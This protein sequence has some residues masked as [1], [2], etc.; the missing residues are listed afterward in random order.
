MAVPT[1]LAIMAVSLT[2]VVGYFSVIGIG[3]FTASVAVPAM[4]LAALIEVIKIALA[5][6]LHHNWRM[7]PFGIKMGGLAFIAV[8]MIIT[9][10]GVHNYLMTA[11]NTDGIK[12][13]QTK[14]EIAV[15]AAGLDADTKQRDFIQGQLAQLSKEYERYAD[16]G[17]VS[18]SRA[19]RQADK[20]ARA[21]LTE[22]LREVQAR[23]AAANAETAR[24]SVAVSRMEAS[25][26]PSM[27]LH[28][29]L[30]I[31][32]D[33]AVNLYT[34]LFL[35]VG[36]PLAVFLSVAAVWQMGQGRA[37]EAGAGAAKGSTLPTVPRLRAMFDRF[38]GTPVSEF[39][40][41]AINLE[42]E[43]AARRSARPDRERA[44]VA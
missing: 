16:L 27:T 40:R 26:G 25:L 41:I 7:L 24:L 5:A 3:Q 12:R 42:K 11:H 32:E 31:S 19:A 28:K 30:G 22:E 43:K 6:W 1:A 14:G 44:V 37:V 4:F 20:E 35:L 34:L 9:A 36:D 29:V 10:L 8:A 21:E 2:T 39:D 18:K 23:I 38:T 33:S 15:L 17:S 13:T